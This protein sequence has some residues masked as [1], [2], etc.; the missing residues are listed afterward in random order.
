MFPGQAPLEQQAHFPKSI[1]F[2]WFPENQNFSY[3][4]TIVGF[5]DPNRINQIKW[6][7]ILAQISFISKRVTLIF[8]VKKHRLI[9]NWIKMA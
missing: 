1:G 2:I 9:N 6:N 8:I 5:T 7:P 4:V 3:P